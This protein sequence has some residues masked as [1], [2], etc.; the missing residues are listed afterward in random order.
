MLSRGG[1]KPL[2]K[3]T[4]F[5]GKT[6]FGGLLH[7]SLVHNGRVSRNTAPHALHRNMVIKAQAY[8]RMASRVRRSMNGI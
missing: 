7:N 3:T 5:D 1:D 4:D 2:H 8:W 6:N